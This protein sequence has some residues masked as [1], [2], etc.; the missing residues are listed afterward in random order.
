MTHPWQNI[1]KA[2]IRTSNVFLRSSKLQHLFMVSR[3]YFLSNP[4]FG[5]SSSKHVCISNLSNVQA[6]QARAH[7]IGR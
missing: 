2:R 3:S 7:G 1:C 6:E 4:L 5:Q